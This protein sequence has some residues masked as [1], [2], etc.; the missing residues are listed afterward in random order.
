[1]ALIHK[2]KNKY[3]ILFAAVLFFTAVVGVIS[4][5]GPTTEM[6]YA[7]KVHLLDRDSP[8]YAMFGNEFA[9]AQ[10]IYSSIIRSEMQ[11]DKNSAKSQAEL[12]EDAIH[13]VFLE[14]RVSTVYIQ[15]NETETAAS[16]VCVQFTDI[17]NTKY[18]YIY[19]KPK[20][21][22]LISI[23]PEQVNDVVVA[24]FSTYSVHNL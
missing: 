10:N 5:W 9:F 22:L 11:K 21:E 12:L 23:P 15:K 24:I 19:F 18:Y 17:D 4:C 13:K 20:S 1:M 3:R 16:A 7:G 8:E 6:R 2:E 14:T